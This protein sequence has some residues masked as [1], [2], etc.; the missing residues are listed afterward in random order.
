MVFCAGLVFIMQPGFACLESGLARSKNSINVATKNVAD[1]IIC[2]F[3]YMVIGFGLM[4]GESWHGLFGTSFLFFNE[5]DPKLLAFF[6]FQLMFCGTAATIISGA[7]AERMSLRAYLVVSALVSLLIYPI[8]GHWAWSGVVAGGTGWLASIGF[9]DFAGGTVVHSV[10]GWVSL[11]AVIIIGP[12]IGRGGPVRIPFRSHSLPLATLGMFIIWFGWIGFNGG[13]LLTAD[14]RVPLII[15]NTMVAGSMGGLGALA[16][17]Y[18]VYNRVGVTDLLSGCLAGLVAITPTAH[19]VSL[20]DAA[21]LS[22]IGGILCLA[23]ARLIEK[24]GIDDAVNAF[25]VHAI[26]GVWGTLCVAI[27]GD[28]ELIGTGLGRLEQFGVQC[29]GVVAAM[30]WAFGLGYVLL[31]LVDLVVKLRVPEAWERVGLNVSE[32][33]ESTDQMELLRLMEH[34]RRTGDFTRPIEVELDSEVGDIARQYN[35]V[36][37]K[38]SAAKAEAEQANATKSKFLASMSHELR[39]PLN[40]IIGFSEMMTRK[41][42]GELG[43]EKYEDYANEIHKSSSHLLDLVNGILNISTIESGGYNLNKSLVDLKT[44]A[45]ESARVASQSVKEKN[46]KLVV[47][48]DNSASDLEADPR[49]MRQIILN[50]LSNAIK[51]TP[52]GGSITVE[53]GASKTLHTV[54]VTDTGEGIDREWLARL[55]EPFATSATNPYLAEGGVGLGLSIVKMLIDLHGGTLEIE[56]E[57]GVGTEV[58]ITLP[59]R[60]PDAGADTGARP[61]G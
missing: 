32:H 11:A 39:T 23:A 5:T 8:F 43:S 47:L 54:S 42:F 53:V 17:G 13:S 1:F 2:T 50:L 12:R 24:A 22:F 41:Y 7:V 33:E 28:L 45:R 37:E 6:M 14:E 46:L 49:A 18:G 48:G 55:T 35:L 16:V 26:P 51:H 25:P 19:C 30:I 58:R 21:V 20:V 10:A 27:F 40:A 56:S 52:T 44:I 57:I 59:T 61:A 34:H 9:V 38:L 36:L 31:R 15:L 3:F 4:F 29:I 60:A